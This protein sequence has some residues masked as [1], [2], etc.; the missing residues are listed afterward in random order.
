MLA[1][2]TGAKL[3]CLNPLE[4]EGGYIVVLGTSTNALIN[5]LR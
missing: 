5:A 3:V 4:Y 1:K 2:E